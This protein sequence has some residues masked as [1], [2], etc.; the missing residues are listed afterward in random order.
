MMI[1]RRD[2]GEG[3]RIGYPIMRLYVRG[4]HYCCARDGYNLQWQLIDGSHDSMR[5]EKAFFTLGNVSYFA[6]IDER[7]VQRGFSGSG[8]LQQFFYAGFPLLAFQ[9]GQQRKTI[10][11]KGGWPSGHGLFPCAAQL[12]VQPPRHGRA[13]SGPSAYRQLDGPDR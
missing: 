7:N 1:P 6:K 3:V 5:Q 4:S 12:D 9:V 2:Y 10:E 11:R 8:A 13:T